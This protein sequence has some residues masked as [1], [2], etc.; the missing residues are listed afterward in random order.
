MTTLNLNQ[1]QRETLQESL[2]SYLSNLR[3]EIADTD[4]HDF[5]EQLKH[6]EVVLKDVL[7]ML[8]SV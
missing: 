3:L 8:E 1:E 5:R 4:N 6:K 7:A 2:T